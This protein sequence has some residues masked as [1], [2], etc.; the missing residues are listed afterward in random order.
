MPGVIY[1]VLPKTTFD[2]S[3]MNGN[4][5]SLSYV[6]TRGIDVSAYMEA[7]A[8][9]RVHSYSIT[10]TPSLKIEFWPEVPTPEDPGLNSEFSGS[11]PTLAWTVALSGLSVP[12]CNLVG[13][14]TSG[15]FLRLK[16]TGVQGAT[17]GTLIATIS[18]DLVARS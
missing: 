13:T 4:N 16:V 14:V 5:Q 2:F 9:F 11:G 12:A 1:R 18:A 7:T 3:S 6:V 8:L 10:H 15:F 17:A